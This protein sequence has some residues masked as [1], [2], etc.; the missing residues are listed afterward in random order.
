MWSMASDEAW[1]R[2]ERHRSSEPSKLA[3]TRYSIGSTGT[4]LLTPGLPW[5][6]KFQFAQA[7]CGICPITGIIVGKIHIRLSIRQ[8][9]EASGLGMRKFEESFKRGGDAE[10]HLTAI[11]RARPGDLNSHEATTWRPR[12]RRSLGGQSAKTRVSASVLS[13]KSPHTAGLNVFTAMPTPGESTAFSIPTRKSPSL[14]L[15][16][17]WASPP[18]LFTTF[19]I[20]S[21]LTWLVVLTRRLGEARRHTPTVRCPHLTS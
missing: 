9:A 11:R 18:V 4:S 21:L 10:R 20:L 2:P 6:R 12:T 19:V 3:T 8:A 5:Y 15:L 7:L 14:R 17:L 13:P 16:R 1:N